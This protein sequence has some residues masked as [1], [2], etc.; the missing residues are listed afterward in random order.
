MSLPILVVFD[1]DETL[2]QFI[3]RAPYHYW[4]DV[5]EEKRNAF[6]Y[7]DND[8]K[9]Q[10][11]VFRPHLREFL[12]FVEQN[13]DVHIALWTYSEQAYARAIA[14]SIERTFG[15]DKDRFVFTYGDEQVT[16]ADERM[17]KNL[18]YIW[19]DR[20]FRGKYHKFN[21]FIVDDRFG[22]LAHEQ[23]KYNGIL[24]EGFEPFG[25]KK[26]RAPMTEE[27]F[28]HAKADDAL[29]HL[30]KIIKNIQKDIGG[31]SEEEIADAFSSEHIFPANDKTC[32]RKG[33]K[34]YMKSHQYGKKEGNTVRMV[35][36]GEIKMEEQHLKGGRRSFS[37]RS[38]R[39][40]RRHRKSQLRR[41]R[42]ARR[43]TTRR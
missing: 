26:E 40:V 42:T 6:T 20:K 39:N 38:K 7:D 37:T 21:T 3:N 23:N 17:P 32:K 34:H 43:N 15:F 11:A 14:S 2:L 31:C 4:E 41:K 5:P 30:M 1:I 8:E 18:E 19:N 27:L 16:D 9:R 29:V 33:L 22:N 24:I 13:P 36:I 35:T 28:Q 25:H 10:C 12:E